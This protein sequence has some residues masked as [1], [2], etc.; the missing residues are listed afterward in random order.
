VPV[1]HFKILYV[2]YLPNMKMTSGP[3]DKQTSAVSVFA[4]MQRKVMRIIASLYATALPTLVKLKQSHYRP[5]QALRV[6]GG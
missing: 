5:G 3:N 6:S 2:S 1:I 4:F